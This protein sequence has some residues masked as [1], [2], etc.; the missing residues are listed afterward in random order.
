MSTRALA[1]R[2]I[3]RMREHCEDL[4]SANELE[5]VDDLLQRGNGA[6]RQVVVYEANH[7]FREVMAEIVAATAV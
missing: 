4:G 5:A 6:S 1:R 2:L 7:D 3:D